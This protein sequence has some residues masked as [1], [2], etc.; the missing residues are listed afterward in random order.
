V[1]AV[2][3]NLSRDVVKLE[4]LPKSINFRKRGKI[5]FIREINP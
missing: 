4:K 3:E 1:N 2:G 5:D